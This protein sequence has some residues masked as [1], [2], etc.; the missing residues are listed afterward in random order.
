MKKL[1]ADLFYEMAKEERYKSPIKDNGIEFEW[2]HWS[3]EDGMLDSLYAKLDFD[4]K[5]FILSGPW[6]H[7]DPITTSD[8]EE[9]LIGVL[10]ACRE[11]TQLSPIKIREIQRF[12][13]EKDRLWRIE[14]GRW[15]YE[16]RSYKIKEV[17][18]TTLEKAIKKARVKTMRTIKYI[19]EN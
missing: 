11:Y 6:M 15:S 7:V 18:A 1:L 2:G 13:G 5:E 10:C 16:N 14:Y 19:K 8:F 4:N 17:R 9:F 12:V 3:S